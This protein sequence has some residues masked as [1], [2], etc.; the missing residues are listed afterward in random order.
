MLLTVVMILVP[1][2]VAKAAVVYSATCNLIVLS[3]IVMISVVLSAG[4]Q[5][6]GYVSFSK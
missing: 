4:I 6:L 5:A 2:L 3:I 1:P